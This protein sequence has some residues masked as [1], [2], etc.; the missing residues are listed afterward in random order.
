MRW[1]AGEKYRFVVY[2]LLHRYTVWTR[3]LFR[4]LSVLGPITEWSIVKLFLG[5]IPE[6]LLCSGHLFQ[7]HPNTSSWRFLCSSR[8]SLLFL[9]CKI[10]L[11]LCSGWSWPYKVLTDPASQMSKI[12]LLSRAPV[13]FV[14]HFWGHTCVSSRNTGL[15]QEPADWCAASWLRGSHA[16]RREK[17]VW[18]PT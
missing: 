14:C 6:Q 12:R 10:S 16:E 5:I 11:L 3:L 17:G 15:H 9:H 4:Y 1:L 18:F 13:Y 7:N 2:C 8:T